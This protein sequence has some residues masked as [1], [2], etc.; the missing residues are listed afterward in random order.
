VSIPSA[1][2]V[3]ARVLAGAWRDPPPPTLDVTQDQ[4][5]AVT[6]LLHR[7]GSG[8]LAW[9]RLR[10][11]PLVETAARAGFPQAYL[12]HATEAKT[13]ALGLAEGLRRLRS[14][15]VE[16]LLVKGW[17]I[18]RR[19]PE[20][21]LR[22]YSDLDLVVR[23][24]VSA[25]A[26]AALA[27]P[28]PLGHPV[29]LH[30]GPA[31]LDALSFDALAERGETLTVDGETVRVPGPEDHLRIMALHALRH[32]IVR[33]IWLID[34]ALAV[35]TRAPGFD[36]ARCLGSDRRRADWVTCAIA[37][38]HQ[39]LGARR[40]HASRR[41]HGGAAAVARSGRAPRVDARRGAQS[42]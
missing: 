27:G 34:L 14:A 4:L 2:A 6:W 39:L 20:I 41:A 10:K 42:P 38:A 17:A 12:I 16:V 35:E 9:W 25:A 3:I 23:P 31:Q 32:A 26:H 36:W 8:A 40:Q 21:G 24:S 30:D 15:G 29:D 1:G 13:H 19:Y 22:H 11:T 37:L 18:A 7:S 28:S 33:P 5:T